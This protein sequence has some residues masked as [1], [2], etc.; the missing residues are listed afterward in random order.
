LE[1]HNTIRQEYQAIYNAVYVPVVWNDNLAADALAYANSLVSN[2][3]S[4]AKNDQTCVQT[5]RPAPIETKFGGE[6]L[7]V[8]YGLNRNANIVLQSWKGSATGPAF[9]QIIWRPSQWIGCGVASSGA[10]SFT[11]CRYV[12]PGNCNVY[13]NETNAIALAMADTSPCPPLVPK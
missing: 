13:A 8:S 4:T 11:V 5:L 3:E 6:N 1:A 9:Y 12:A 2:Y 10:C 7:Y